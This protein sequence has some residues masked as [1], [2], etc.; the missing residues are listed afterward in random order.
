M[1]QL[2][3]IFIFSFSMLLVFPSSA[4]I[5]YPFPLPSDR[6]TPPDSRSGL[7]PCG[8][9][10]LSFLSSLPLASPPTEQVQS[11]TPLP[12]PPPQKFRHRHWSSYFYHRPKV[13]H[14][15]LFSAGVDRQRLEQVL[16]LSQ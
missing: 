10:S 12:H 3:Q 1:V 8:V 14:P 11:T 16:R 4:S 9:P 7:R 15:C 2:M 13:C 5:S 6:C